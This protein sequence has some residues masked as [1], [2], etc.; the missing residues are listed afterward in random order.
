MIFFTKAETQDTREGFSVPNRRHKR[1][2]SG[3]YML[4][5]EGLVR[6]E[7]DVDKFVKVLMEIAKDVKEKSSKRVP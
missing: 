3:E 4:R 1:A 5:V 2:Q 6:P 7:V